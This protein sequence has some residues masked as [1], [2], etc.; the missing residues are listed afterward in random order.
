MI[1]Q[2]LAQATNHAHHLEV[3]QVVRRASLQAEKQT[4]FRPVRPSCGWSLARRRALRTPAMLP[5]PTSGPPTLGFG[6]LRRLRSPK[7]P[8][9][10]GNLKEFRRNFKETLLQRRLQS[11]TNSLKVFSSSAR[12]V[13]VC[14]RSFSASALIRDCSICTFFAFSTA[15]FAKETFQTR[16]PLSIF[17]QRMA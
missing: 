11:I 3:L 2:L 15:S 5:S 13:L 7:A 8:T 9:S 4:D 14:S 16:L 10:H 17:K 1:L 12:E 6:S